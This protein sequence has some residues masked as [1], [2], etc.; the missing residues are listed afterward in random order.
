MGS[1]RKDEKKNARIWDSVGTE[2][3]EETGRKNQ[4]KRGRKENRVEREGESEKESRLSRGWG[5]RRRE[6]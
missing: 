4:R 3:R 1:G 2:T 6:R 5:S